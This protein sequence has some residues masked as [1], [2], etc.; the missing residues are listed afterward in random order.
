[1]KWKLKIICV[2]IGRTKM[3]RVELTALSERDN[4]I[5]ISH[6]FA[7]EWKG[8]KFIKNSTSFH[9]LNQVL[10]NHSDHDH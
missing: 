2:L 5:S 4:F 1:M 9:F 7:I 10:N 3:K 8:R 6:L